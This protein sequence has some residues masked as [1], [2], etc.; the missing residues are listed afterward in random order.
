MSELVYGIVS[1][2]IWKTGYKWIMKLLPPIVV[3]PVIMVIGLGLA[4]MAVDMA[5]NIPIPDT[6]LK[7]YSFIHFS[8]ALVTLL[9]AIFCTIYFKNIL[10]TMPIL[11]GISSWVY[12]LSCHWNY[13]FFSSKGSN[14]V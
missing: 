4:G 6:D 12:I 14:M 10:S 2:I 9:T 3:A 11:I 8:A 13:R 7:E 5:M 1:L